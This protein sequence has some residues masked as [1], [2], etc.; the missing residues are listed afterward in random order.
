MGFFHF[1]WAWHLTHSSTL[2]SS[3]P[4][5]GS[6]IHLFLAPCFFCNFLISMYR[7]QSPAQ[8]AL[9]V[10]IGRIQAEPAGILVNLS[11]SMFLSHCRSRSPHNLQASSAA[12]NLQHVLYLSL[13]WGSSVFAAG[14]EGNVVL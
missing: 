2:F 12:L 10:S 4:L 14:E 1:L 7:S 9:F 6:V 13:L 11:L 5:I 8:A 3:Q